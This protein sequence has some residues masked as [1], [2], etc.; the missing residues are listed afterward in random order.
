MLTL[1]VPFAVT[2]SVL[3]PHPS[4]SLRGPQRLLAADATSLTLIGAN[5]TASV[6]QAV[7]GV[8]SGVAG[9]LALVETTAKVCVG[10][11][12]R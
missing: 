7:A 2:C 9:T 4:T 5:A 8:D 6:T 10:W 12:M 11:V 3:L 1:I